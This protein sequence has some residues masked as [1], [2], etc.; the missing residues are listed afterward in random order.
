M[1]AL[2]DKRYAIDYAKI[3]NELKYKPLYSLEEGL[4]KTIEWIKPGTKAKKN[5]INNA[6][7]LQLL[8]DYKERKKNNPNEPIPN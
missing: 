5:Y 8:V 2:D 6:D 7:F 4:Q 1:T 3:E